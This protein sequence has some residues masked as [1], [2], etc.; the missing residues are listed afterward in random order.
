MT[1]KKPMDDP[2]T[3]LSIPSESVPV[4]PELEMG[5]VSEPG[6]RTEAPE[7][8]SEIPLDAGELLPAR[9]GTPRAPLD[10]GMV[11]A[12]VKSR[13]QMKV[14]REALD[15]LEEGTPKDVKPILAL[16][17]L[18]HS[19]F[20]IGMAFG[21]PSAQVRQVVERYGVY[22]KGNVR[23]SV[24]REHA[25]RLIEQR[26]A[27]AFLV[28]SPGRIA[29]LDSK[30]LTSFMK[31]AAACRKTFGPAAKDED[32]GT[33]DIKKRIRTLQALG[34]KHAQAKL[35][36]KHTEEDEDD[37]TGDEGDEE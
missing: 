37:E 16:Y 33:Q 14:P 35:L 4:G 20:A 11:V 9:P 29:R 19:V 31:A 26:M 24:H 36:K 32:E 1:K 30:D 2:E 34:R 18:R 25:A 3:A 6:E 5:G 13:N 8:A 17:A 7:P 27:D 12:A 10:L 22:I 23:D 28:M 15:C 21:I